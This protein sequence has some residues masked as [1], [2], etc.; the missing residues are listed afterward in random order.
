MNE[1][2]TEKYL[3]L[4][5]IGRASIRLNVSEREGGCQFL[6][7]GFVIHFKV[8]KATK[9][10]ERLTRFDSGTSSLLIKSFGSY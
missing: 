8:E 10:F 7:M 3:L 2:L 5:R 9:L 1:A 4:G 6:L